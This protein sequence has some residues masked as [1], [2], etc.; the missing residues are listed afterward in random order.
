MAGRF[1]DAEEAFWKQDMRPAY[2]EQKVEFF[3]LTL[4]DGTAVELKA[5]ID[6]IDVD[7]DGNFIIVDY[8]TGKYPLPKMNLEQDIFQLP[9]YAFMRPTGP[10]RQRAGPQKTNRPCVLRSCRKDRGRRAG[11]CSL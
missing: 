10:L 8:K 6:R 5:R 1:L 4:S 3:T 2:I 7:E 9:V 11:R